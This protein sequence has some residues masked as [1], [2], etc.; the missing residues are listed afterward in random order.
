MK[1]QCNNKGQKRELGSHRNAIHDGI[2]DITDLEVVLRAALAIV[3]AV[4]R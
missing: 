4:R 2:N 3:V 1:A